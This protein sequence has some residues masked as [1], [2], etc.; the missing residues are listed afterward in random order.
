MAL[1]S[2]PHSYTVPVRASPTARNSSDRYKI[3]QWE[4]GSSVNAP[5]TS[6]YGCENHTCM[7]H[8]SRWASFRAKLNSNRSALLHYFP[9]APLLND[10]L[11]Q[12]ASKVEVLLRKEVEELKMQVS[13]LICAAAADVA[14]TKGCA[15]H[16]TPRDRERRDAKE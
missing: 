8:I 15:Q 11:Y 1:D 6:S 7:N 5:Q 12:L 14:H 16:E 13:V 4:T 9:T 10:E 3:S 2:F